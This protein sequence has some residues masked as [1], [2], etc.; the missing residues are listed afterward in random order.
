MYAGESNHYLLLKDIQKELADFIHTGKTSGTE[1][2]V[3]SELQEQALSSNCRGSGLAVTYHRHQLEYMHRRFSIIFPK[4]HNPDNDV[5]ISLVPWFLSP[6]HP[7]PVFVYLYASGHYHANGKASLAQSAAAAS[8]VFGIDR[9]NKSTV[10]RNMKFEERFISK[11]DISGCLM[12]KELTSTE[13]LIGFIPE[14]LKN[15]IPIE[16]PEKKYDEVSE[17]FQELAVSTAAQILCG[18]PEKYFQVIKSKGLKRE[19]RRD[20]RVR[21]PRPRKRG[22]RRVQRQPDFVDWQQREEIRKGF[23]ET[24]RDFVMNAAVKYHQFV[25]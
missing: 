2:R 23:I 21:P 10:S 5:T 18:I 13:E 3:L 17:F 25:V 9:L 7:Y 19:K 8:K 15:L 14:L 11:P 6:G 1:F 22:V 24:S 16:L 12:G 4:V 20:M